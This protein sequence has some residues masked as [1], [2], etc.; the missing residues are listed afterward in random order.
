MNPL[1][2]HFRFFQVSVVSVHIDHMHNANRYQRALD[3]WCKELDVCG[4]L[5]VAGAPACHYRLVLRG[6]P[7]ATSEF[8]KRLRTRPVDV[9]RHGR[10]CRERMATVLG[11]E[12]GEALANHYDA[13]SRGFSTMAGSTLAE[14]EPQLRQRMGLS[15]ALVALTLAIP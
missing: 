2:I 12:A 11:Q 7:G 5:L 10:P 1:F 15:D 4:L 13:E 3:D 8:L 9:D 14:F 6:A